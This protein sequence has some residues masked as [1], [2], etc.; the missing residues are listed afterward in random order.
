MKTKKM[1]FI[2]LII[3]LF[4]SLIFIQNSTAEKNKITIEF[5]YTKD[6]TWCNNTKP[7][8]NDIEEKY[9]DNITVNRLFILSMA[10]ENYT[11]LNSTYKQ[12]HLPVVVVSNKTNYTLFTPTELYYSADQMLDIENAII[13]MSSETEV[14][15]EHKPSDT[16]NDNNNLLLI[17]FLICIFIGTI[18]IIQILLKRKKQ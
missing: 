7:V 8:I 18:F 4:T 5:F 11:Y 3:I 16:N 6:C 9:Q 14:N 12:T 1:Y 13:S 10:S 2:T 17:G 15:P